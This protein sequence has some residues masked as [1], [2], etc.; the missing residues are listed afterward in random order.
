VIAV[1]AINSRSP[2]L[3]YESLRGA[4]TADLDAPVQPRAA[5][6]AEFIADAFGPATAGVLHYGSHVH[7]S[8]A[9]SESAYDFFV[10]VDDN[11]AAYRSFAA[12][13]RPGFSAATAAALSR[14]LPPN[15]VGVR[16]RAP[17]DGAR[18]SAKVA[19]VSLRQ[20]ARA[21]ARTSPDH[22]LRGRLFQPVRLPWVRDR[23]SR[24]SIEQALI[25]ARRSTFDWVRPFLPAAFDTAAYGRTL[26]AT[27]FSGE[28]R[29]ETS[30]R[31]EQL[32]RA[33]RAELLAI[34]EPLLRSLAAGGE[35][36]TAG[37]GYRLSQPVTRAE[38]VRVTLYFKRSKVRA[39]A[40]WS[41]YVW[42]YDGWLEY[43]QRKVE[44][45][46]GTVIELTP[47]ERQ[48]PLVFLWPKAIRYLRS[49]R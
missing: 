16:P 5:A 39:T 48:W 20:F 45:R 24:E 41:K 21:C 49:R 26:L 25:E 44:R 14:V 32:F 37:G 3:L 43:L 33:Q 9:S 4:L 34:Y 38:R 29:P 2:G 12:C 31:A 6:L 22:F 46:G 19:I 7:G 42:L 18:V 27:S 15:I 28:I 10:V 47:R 30:D 11:A 40:R 17:I 8:G 1:A 23:E 35:L 13:T 36:A